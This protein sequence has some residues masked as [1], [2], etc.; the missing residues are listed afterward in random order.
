MS[1]LNNKKEINYDT[2]SNGIDTDEILHDQMTQTEFLK[3]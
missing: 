1:N 3:F 2:K